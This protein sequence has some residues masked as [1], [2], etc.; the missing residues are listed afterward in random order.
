M[1]PSPHHRHCQCCGRLI[2]AKTGTIAHHGYQRPGHGWQTGSCPGAKYLPFE[3][4]RDRLGWMI[5]SMRDFEAREV[6]NIAA[7]GAEARPVFHS[8]RNRRDPRNPTELRITRATWDEV[9][10]EHEWHF[11][12]YSLYDFDRLKA[13]KLRSLDRQLKC[14]RDD[15]ATQQARYDAWKPTEIAA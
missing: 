14:L 12:S 13:D 6:A 11:R 2:G 10:K 15:I 8:I 7:I 4:N 1:K 9:F 3:Q 5:D